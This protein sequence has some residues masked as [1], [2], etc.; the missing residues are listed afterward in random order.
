MG[1]TSKNSYYYQ[2]LKKED[3]KNIF[4]GNFNRQI[5]IREKIGLSTQVIG[6][7]EREIGIHY[8]NQYIIKKIYY[9]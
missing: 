5:D 4:L 3:G 8:D 6:L 2:V 7:I 1:R 9:C